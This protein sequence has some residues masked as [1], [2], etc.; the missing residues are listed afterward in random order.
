MNTLTLIRL[1]MARLWWVMLVISVVG[2]ALGYAWWHFD[3]LQMSDDERNAYDDG[4]K[5]FNNKWWFPWG[6]RPMTDDMVLVAIDD[7]TFDDV[8]QYEPWHNRYGNWPYDRAIW[9]D[10]ISFLSEADASLVLMDITLSENKPDITGDKAMGDAIAAAKMPVV[11]GFNALQLVPPLARVDHPV[12]RLHVPR[13]PPPPLQKKDEEEMTEFPEEPSPQEVARLKAEEA[14]KLLDAAAPALAFPIEFTGGLEAPV[15]EPVPALGGADG[16]VATLD[17]LKRDAGLTSIELPRYPQPPIAQVIDAASGFGAVDTEA[18]DDGKMRETK[19]AYSDGNNTYVTIA[20][21]AI[22]DYW[23][24]DKITLS[25]GKLQVGTH[26]VRVNADGSARINFGGKLQDR[27]RTVSL[28]DVLRYSSAKDDPKLRQEGLDRFKGKMVFIG[29]LAQGAGDQKAT[30]FAAAEGGVVKQLAIADNML[31]DRFILEAPEWASLLL[32]FVVALISVALV[33]VAQSFI[34][35]VGAPVF[36]TFAFFV[37]TG[38]FITFTNI[39][40]LSAMPGMAGTLAALAATAFNRFLASKDREFL[41]DAFSS[42]VDPDVLDR[43][44]E[45]HKL[46][47]LDGENTEITAFFSDIRGFSTFTEQLKDDPKK[48][49]RLLHD[50]LSAVTPILKAHGACIDKYIGDAVVALFG[51]PVFHADHALRA[52]RAALAVQA[53]IAELRKDFAQRGLPDVYTRVGLNTDEMLVGNM[54]SRDRP[55]NYTAIGDGM[56][57]AARLEGTNKAYETLILIGPKTYEAVKS[58]MVTREVDSVRVAGKHD[59]S[60]IYE[61][62]GEE[63]Q[64]SAQKK[65]VLELYGKALELYRHKRF[66]D[67]LKTLKEAYD[68]DKTD[69]PTKVLAG[70][71]NQF[72]QHPPPADWDGVT[73]LEK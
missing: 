40:I 56:N 38:G 65:Q 18:D 58:Q 6:Q 14:K 37:V 23:K 47:A 63:G 54:G 64:V 10:V 34:T 29:A 43:L 69:G 5:R 1:R 31:H 3:F 72:M 16:G 32:A 39:H 62:V 42:Y 9:A 53:R 33:M 73:Q 30:P 17:D 25:P 66:A 22:A 67:S 57:L 4:L 68:L 11:M 48:L 2:T 45:S 7:A 60:V 13:P 44:V 36:L 46:P 15:F 20:V 8:A 19:F 55:I 49:M 70:K 28:G 59:A 61:L 41:R 21:A 35:D 12:N 24:A 52:C 50:Y 26:T 71:C 27:F 51:A